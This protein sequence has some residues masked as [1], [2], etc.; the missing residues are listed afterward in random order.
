MKKLP[1]LIAFLYIV[2]IISTACSLDTSGGTNSG[3]NMIIGPL[4][5]NDSN[6]RYF[7]DDS[8]KAIYLTGSHTWSNLKDMGET[9]PPPAF[10][11]NGYLNFLKQYNHNFIRLWTWELTKYQYSGESI[12]Y[13]TPFPW[14]RTGPGIALDGKPKFDLTKFNQ[15][16]FD[17]LK[18]RVMLAKEKGIYVSIMLFEG[19]G[20]FFSNPPWR[21]DGHP[22]N[23]NNNINGI[24]GDL[25]KDGRGLESHTLQIPKIVK[26][27]EDYVKKVIDTVNDLDNVLYEIS[28]EDHT[29]SIEW[30]YHMIDLIHNYEKTKPKQHPVGMTTHTKL[31]NDI[32]FNSPADWISPSVAS[33]ANQNDPY[34]IGPPVADGK[35]VMILDTDHLWGLGGDRIWVW[36]S[37]LRGYN[38]I[39]MDPLDSNATREEA[40]RAMGHTLIYANKMNI[41]QMFPRNDLA[42]TTYCLANPGMEYLVY[43]PLA[44]ESFTVNLSTGTYSY[45]WFNPDSGTIVLSGAFTAQSGKK[46]FSAPFIGDAVLYI[47]RQ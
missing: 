29:D 45:E 30:Q 12:K 31:G 10:D 16:F 25:N 22:F 32:A 41:K 7:T 46:D 14:L 42:T 43:Q 23:I 3:N 17:R 13:A 21:W 44:N 27:E 47:K 19:H 15:E 33:S 9:D 4:R 39:Y 26:I 5:V 8:G 6:P 37:F 20:I 36:K 35:K 11:Y 1:I 40:R 24:D 28:N 2:I 18:S 34:K 38:P